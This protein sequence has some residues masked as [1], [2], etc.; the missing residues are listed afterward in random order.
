MFDKVLE[1]QSSMDS[2]PKLSIPSN[3]LFS[4]ETLKEEITK[5]EKL[6]RHLI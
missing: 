4:F 1:Q 3:P 2:M 5:R 6:S